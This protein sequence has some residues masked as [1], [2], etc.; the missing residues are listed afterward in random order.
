MNSS[1]L[2]FGPHA[3]GQAFFQPA[4]LALAPHVH[5]DLAVVA[6]LA[7]VHGVLGDAPPEEPLAPFARERIVVVTGRP[8]AANQAQLFGGSVV[9]HVATHPDA[10]PGTRGP[11]VDDSGRGCVVELL[12]LQ[13]VRVTADSRQTVG[14][15]QLFFDCK[16]G[17][18]K[19]IRLNK[20]ENIG[21][22]QISCVMI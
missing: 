13:P 2:T 19:L 14:R 6:V 10:T 9:Q 20:N 16:H 15:G 22:Q 21:T 5:V 4:L 18:I 11:G 7:L 12:L 17:R 3:D 8:V 1:I